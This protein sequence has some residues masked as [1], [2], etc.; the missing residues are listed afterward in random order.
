MA[1]A[2]GFF[3]VA[4]RGA[5]V[6]RRIRRKNKNPTYRL[7]RF[8]SD[9]SG[10]QMFKADCNRL[11]RN[12]RQ[13]IR[14]TIYNDS[15]VDT[16]RMQRSTRSRPSVYSIEIATARLQEQTQSTEGS[17]Q[18]ILI[19]P[20]VPYA[21]YV[22]RLYS[23]WI[24]DGLRNTNKSNKLPRVLVGRISGRLVYQELIDG[25][26]GR[27]IQRPARGRFRVS[28]DRLIDEWS[29]WRD[30]PPSIVMSVRSRLAFEVLADKYRPTSRM[31]VRAI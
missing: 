18:E 8:R 17:V 19:G 27:L 20:R 4:R 15:P 3:R 28:V 24:E 29:A 30:D 12:R 2:A 31:E 6:R 26:R 22:S 5:S 7:V 10:E 1:L 13:A 9:S 21:I 23:R 25:R 11:V 14:N 16:G